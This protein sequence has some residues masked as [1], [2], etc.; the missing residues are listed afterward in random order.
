VIRLCT[1][2]GVSNDAAQLGPLTLAM[3][4]GEQGPNAREIAEFADFLRDL[5]PDVIVFS[6]A[7]LVGALRTLREKCGHKSR[8]YCMLQGDD[9]FLMD[10][11]EKYRQAAIAKIHER[12]RDFDGFLTHSRYYR[13]YMSGLLDL[14]AG[15]FHHVPLGIDV[16]AHDGRPDAR[17]NPRFT[18]GYFARICPEKGL[19][20]LVEAFRIL[21]ARHP[22]TRLV[23]GGYLGKRDRKYFKDVLRSARPL[24]DA[25]HYAGSPDAQ[26]EK[27]ELLKSF[28]VFSVPTEYHEPKGLPVLEALANGTPVVQPR[29]GAFP[30]LI[31]ATGGGLLVEP[32]DP[33]ELADALE[34]LL[35]DPQRRLELA[36]AGHANVRR[37]FTEA[38]L[39]AASLAVFEQ[40]RAERPTETEV[41]TRQKEPMA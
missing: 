16:S 23:A 4:D 31:E 14:P 10:L 5:A 9:I 2:F 15:R 37:H 12:C 35:L 21:H 13:D 34:A 38:A 36:R 24:G 1:R 11:P 29:H 19:H 8:V 20:R 32:N 41:L 27:S 25:F 39:A 18:V 22:N 3:L 26:A 6:N 7:L 33:Q 28:D 40:T 17:K 30:E